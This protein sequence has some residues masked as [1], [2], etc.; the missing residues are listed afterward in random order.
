MAKTKIDIETYMVPPILGPKLFRID[1][2]ELTFNCRSKG[3]L[4]KEDICEI[5]EAVNI[6]GF[7]TP[8]LLDQDDVVLFW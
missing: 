5:V 4:Y 8:V 6:T 7:L 1:P 2:N 3:E